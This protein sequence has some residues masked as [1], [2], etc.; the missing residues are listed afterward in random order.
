LT[1]YDSAGTHKFGL[2]LDGIE[3][4]TIKKVDGLRLKIDKVETKSNNLQGQGHP[5]GVGR[6]PGV[7]GG[8]HGHPGADR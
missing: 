7:P 4:K 3:S 6:Q 1:H 5:Q 2:T 8:A